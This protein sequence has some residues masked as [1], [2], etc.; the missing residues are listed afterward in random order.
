MATM[1]D[2]APGGRFFYGGQ[3]EQ[4]RPWEEQP[5]VQD[6]NKYKPSLFWEDQK[7]RLDETSWFEN[8]PWWIQ[9]PAD[10]F[11]GK[12]LEGEIATA[13]SGEAVRDV[14]SGLGES[15]KEREARL[16]KERKE[17]A[18]KRFEESQAERRMP[19]YTPSI[20]KIEEEED[21]MDKYLKYM[22]ISNLIGGTAAEDYAGTS[23]VSIGQA[24]DWPTMPPMFG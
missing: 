14:I 22:L 10:W 11:K 4:R 24:R 13:E 16:D 1:Q 19:T 15:K 7:R 20:P 8:A 21:F 9:G 12:M 18:A 17:A 23:T 2:F 5:L 6:P 3:Y